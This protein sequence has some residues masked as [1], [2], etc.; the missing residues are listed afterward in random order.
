MDIS[1]AFDTIRPDHIKEEMLKRTESEDLV[2]WYY[3]YLVHRNM[4]FD[5]QGATKTISNSLGF[6]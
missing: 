4:D 5:L 1:S 3:N 2:E 6:P